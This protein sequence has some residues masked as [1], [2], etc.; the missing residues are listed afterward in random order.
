MN[1]YY[2]DIEDKI[3]S[4]VVEEGG[5]YYQKPINAGD[6]KLYGVEFDAKADMSKLVN[7]LSVYGNLSFM[8]GRI[9][10]AVDGI[11]RDLKDVPEY[12]MNLG[13]D[14]KISTWGLTIG[15]L[16][17]RL[18]GFDVYE[19][20]TK[21]KREEDRTMLDIYALKTLTKNLSLRF[22]AKNLTKVDKEKHDTEY[23]ASGRV[24]KDTV[25]TEHSYA[26]FFV[27][28]EGKF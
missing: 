3:E 22:S 12:A 28:L 11:V 24:K 27:A 18:G 5:L 10:S 21:Q 20:A 1:G 19:S 23:Y 7:G 4:S 14:Q 25:D 26:S 16:A 17:N 9:K 15:A 2:R 13:F 6:A 8:H